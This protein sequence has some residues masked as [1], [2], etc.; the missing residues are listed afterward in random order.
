MAARFDEH[1]A[2][3]CGRGG[4]AGGGA[5]HFEQACLYTSPA[6]RY[7]NNVSQRFYE[8]RGALVKTGVQLGGKP[9][10]GKREEMRRKKKIT[11]G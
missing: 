4:D 8:T 5:V 9:P 6:I 1:N 11:D 10:G 7:A 3:A 2:S